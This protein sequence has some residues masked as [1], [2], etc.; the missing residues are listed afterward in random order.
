MLVEQ[1]LKIDL[2]PEDFIYK[3]K[4][5]HRQVFHIPIRDMVLLC[6]KVFTV[7]SVIK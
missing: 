7:L 1:I 4:K 2:V 6:L 3:D 5:K